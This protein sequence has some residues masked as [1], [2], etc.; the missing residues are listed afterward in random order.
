MMYALKLSSFPLFLF[1]Y[2]TDHQQEGPCAT[3]VKTKILIVE[4]VNS[5]TK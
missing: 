5:V 2:L 3:L 1:L 4:F